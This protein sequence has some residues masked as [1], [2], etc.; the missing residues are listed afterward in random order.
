M[1][2]EE[3]EEEDDNSDAEMAYSKI[4]TYQNQADY[5]GEHLTGE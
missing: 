5:I 4:E 1:L 3:E 2:S